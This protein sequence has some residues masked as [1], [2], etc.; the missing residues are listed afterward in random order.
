MAI[1][2]KFWDGFLE[3]NSVNFSA[4]VKSAMLNNGAEMLDLSCM[5]NATKIN[6][7]GLKNWSLDIETEDDLAASG[8]GSIDATLQPL[9]GAAAFPMKFRISQTD[10]IST[11]N[12]EY[13]GN[14]VLPSCP[15]GG[16]HGAPL[17]KRFTLVCAGDLT[18]DTTP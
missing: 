14:V 16:A 1:H 12:P 18:R 3:V 7:A 2:G 6:A 17:R 13:Q 9:I 8:A 4:R 11:T 15:I 10:A 5:G